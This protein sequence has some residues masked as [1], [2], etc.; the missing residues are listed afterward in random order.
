MNET[1]ADCVALGPQPGGNRCRTVGYPGTVA[2]A[3]Q[4]I[5]FGLRGIAFSIPVLIQKGQRTSPL[6][7][8]VARAGATSSAFGAILQ[9]ASNGRPAIDGWI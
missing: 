8:N 5:L 4:I 9:Q 2:G 6:H 1:P 3:R 7:E